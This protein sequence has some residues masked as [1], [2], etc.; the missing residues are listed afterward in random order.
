[1]D[2]SDD[3]KQEDMSFNFF[4]TEP[5]SY[6][7][8]YQHWLQATTRRHTTDRDS[9]PYG[10]GTVLWQGQDDG[11]EGMV[12][13]PQGFFEEHQRHFRPY[14]GDPDESLDYEADEEGE[15]DYAQTRRSGRGKGIETFN[16][17]HSTAKL[18]SASCSLSNY[19]MLMA[20]D[21]DV[22]HL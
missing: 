2:L 14:K 13:I 18:G 10:K 7:S 3:D 4:N 16:I 22:A 12:H 6:S 17:D 11:F 15:S 1:M 20:T 9:F 21:E 8:P 5:T 19:S